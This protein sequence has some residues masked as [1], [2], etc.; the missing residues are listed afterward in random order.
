MRGMEDLM[1]IHLDPTR[2][3]EARERKGL[4]QSKAAAAVGLQKAAIS[5]YELGHGLP[6]ADVLAR[7]CALYEVEIND[8]T[9]EVAA[10]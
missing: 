3:R 1:T 7:L 9:A 5:K 4:S 10:A 6:S 2:F 8:L